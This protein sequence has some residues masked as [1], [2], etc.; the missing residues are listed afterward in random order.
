MSNTSYP[1]PH[2]KNLSFADF[3]RMATDETLSAAER[4][5]FP[6]DMR[7]GYETAI[8]SDILTKLPAVA[9]TGRTVLDIGLGAGLL[10]QEIVAHCVRQRHALFAVDSDTVLDQLPQ[11]QGFVKMPGQFPEIPNLENYDLPATGFDAVIVYSVLQHVFLEASVFDFVD[12][13][14]SFLAAGGQMLIG[15][16]PN[17]SMLKRF[18]SSEKGIVHHHAFMQSAEPPEV[19]F[20]RL[21]RGRIDDSVVLGILARARAA[22]YDAWIVPQPESLP[23]HQR[24][25]DIVI[26]RP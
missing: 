23:F 16:V 26:R 7:A 19:Q 1:P 14:M 12:T 21:E 25:E 9:D 24:R 20:N 6:D 22:G 18:L 17:V 13:A 8:L 11:S 10:G 4:I 2:L 15:D 3:R 5:G